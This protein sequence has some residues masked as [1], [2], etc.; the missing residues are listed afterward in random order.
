[1]QTVELGIACGRC[2]QDRLR[3]NLSQSSMSLL[4][5]NLRT[6]PAEQTISIFYL[7]CRLMLFVTRHMHLTWPRVPFRDN[8]LQGK[9]FSSRE[10]VVNELQ[11]FVNPR[12]PLFYSKK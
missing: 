2:C 12:S 7:T 5:N 6:H 10:A 8:Y 9:Q 1:M 11:D 3:I 4:H